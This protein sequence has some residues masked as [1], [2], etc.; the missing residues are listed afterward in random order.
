MSVVSTKTMKMTISQKDDWVIL[1]FSGFIDDSVVKVFEPVLQIPRAKFL[2][3]LGDVKN[4][5]S[6]GIAEWSGM[7]QQLRERGIVVL[8]RCMP[9]IVNIL[10]MIPAFADGAFVRSFFRL[11]ACENDHERAV[12]VSVD[13]KNPKADLQV[14][15]SVN[16]S[17]CGLA[18]S[19][20]LDYEEECAFLDLQ[21]AM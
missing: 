12:L 14:V 4:I 7:I 13:L 16:C 10:N 21:Q 3:D 17:H 18:M 9:Q 2:L 11:Y 20:Q 6:C 15:G 1:S 19:P 8:D 5:N